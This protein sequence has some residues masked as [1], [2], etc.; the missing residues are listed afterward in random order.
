MNYQRTT[1]K[2]NT[3]LD[4]YHKK[5]AHLSIKNIPSLVN[6]QRQDVVTHTVRAF[7]HKSP[8]KASPSTVHMSGVKHPAAHHLCHLGRSWEAQ[9]HS[10]PEVTE[11]E[12]GKSS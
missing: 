8:P 11:E 3:I 6:L 7:S 5:A 9:A 1:G 4:T 12:K 10:S 2:S